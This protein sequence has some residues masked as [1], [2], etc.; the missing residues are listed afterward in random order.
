M[1]VGFELLGKCLRDGSHSLQL[2]LQT[3]IPLKAEK[4][5]ANYIPGEIAGAILVGCS[6]STVAAR[7]LPFSLLKDE[8]QCG[9]F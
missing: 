3:Y 1:F 4:D 5:F 6:S 2:Y 8:Q 7:L 9:A